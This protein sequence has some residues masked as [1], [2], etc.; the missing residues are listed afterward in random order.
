[1]AEQRGFERLLIITSWTHSRRPFCVDRY[2]FRQ[3]NIALFYAAPPYPAEEAQ[4]WWRYPA[5]RRAVLSELGKSIFY[6]LVYGLNLRECAP[7]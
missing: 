3:S 4:Y 6:W 2:T 7:M 1:M 5:T